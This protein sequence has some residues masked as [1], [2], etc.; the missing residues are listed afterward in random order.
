MKR[1]V[2]ANALLSVAACS[3]MAFS[4]VS[5]AADAQ[6][7]GVVSLDRILHESAPAR[8]ATDKLQKE[9]SRRKAEIDQMAEAFK[10]KSENFQKNEATM[11]Q[12]QRLTV[13]REL[14]EDERA[15]NRAQRAFREETAQRQNEEIQ[16]I[17]ARANQV[18]LDI[19]RR[20]NYDLIVQE[21]VYASPRIDM[22]Q[23]VLDALK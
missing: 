16:I 3:A 7:I 18:I 1:N 19:A 8:A 6:K 15:L 12:T 11:N 23:K 5:A 17:I 14:A 10:T 13:Q 4:G 9:F 22:T 20:E 21:A 2:F